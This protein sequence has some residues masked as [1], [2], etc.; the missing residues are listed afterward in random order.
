MARPGFPLR[1]MRSNRRLMASACI[2]RISGM[3]A[4]R[5]NCVT[6]RPSA[7][8]SRSWSTTESIADRSGITVRTREGR[9][10]SS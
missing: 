2:F 3:A 5:K 1:E 8:H 9:P 10:S 4:S 6:S 7:M